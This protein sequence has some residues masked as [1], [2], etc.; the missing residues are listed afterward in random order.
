MTAYMA[1]IDSWR[2]CFL[3]NTISTFSTFPPF[4][5]CACECQNWSGCKNGVKRWWEF[6]SDD[7]FYIRTRGSQVY[8]L[9]FPVTFSTTSWHKLYK[10]REETGFLCETRPKSITW[11]VLL[12]LPLLHR[13]KKMEFCKKNSLNFIY[14]HFRANFW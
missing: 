7:I 11:R 9:F 2:V 10:N 3:Q 14:F 13:N 6:R 1:S 5:C 12:L 8:F 4:P